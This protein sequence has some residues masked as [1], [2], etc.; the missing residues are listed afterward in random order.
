MPVVRSAHRFVPSAS[1]RRVTGSCS[2]RTVFARA[3]HTLKEGVLLSQ[4]AIVMQAGASIDGRLM[5][6]TGVSLD[7]NRVTA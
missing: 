5:S 1:C 2:P 4:T 3:R 6:G 7:C